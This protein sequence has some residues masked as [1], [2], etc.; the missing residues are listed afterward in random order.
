MN[1]LQNKEILRDLLKQ[2]DVMNTV[3]G[4]VRQ[5]DLRVINSGDDVEIFVSNPSVRP[6][7]FDFTVFNN[8]LVINVLLKNEDV[9]SGQSY[10]YPIF[11]KV[12]DI[13]FFTDLSRLDAAY[14]NGRFRIHLP[15]NPSIPRRPVSLR[16]RNLGDG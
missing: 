13:P 11:T 2:G 5:T 10:S 14:E 16:I 4:G 3:N 8:K 9:E 1:Y 7:C 6:E 12:I 15:S